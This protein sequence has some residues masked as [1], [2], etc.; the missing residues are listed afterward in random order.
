M[1]RSTEVGEEGA[2]YDG[3]RSEAGAAARYI[4]G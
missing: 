1:A 4:P 3:R 2:R